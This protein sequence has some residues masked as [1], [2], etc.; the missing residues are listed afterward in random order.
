M[1]IL[2]FDDGVLSVTSFVFSIFDG[3]D[4]IR[5]LMLE[6]RSDLGPYGRFEMNDCIR[7][8]GKT[9]DERTSFNSYGTS[10]LQSSPP[11]MPS[12]RIAIP[13]RDYE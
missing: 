11:G 5:T 3:C 9:E 6:T 12:E 10:F 1:E 7:T 8:Q 13:R 2:L 4:E